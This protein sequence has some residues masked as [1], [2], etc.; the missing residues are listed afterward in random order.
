M[1]KI[2]IVLGSTR[3]DRAGEAI[4]QW[5]ADIAKDRGTN[6]DYE[7][8][9]LKS[10]NVPVLTS[11]VLPMMANKQYDDANVQ[12]WSNAIDACDA[13][14]FVTPEYNHS[15]PGPF[16][17]AFDSLGGEWQG[18]TIAFVGY[19]FSG[20]VR[21]VEAWRLA[22]ANFQ[23]NQL[24]S[25][26]EVSVITDFNEGAFAPADFKIGLVDNVLAE[27]EGTF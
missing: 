26:V 4:A 18:K 12:A 8:I 25:Q 21:A 15:V 5:V 3:D 16:K 9:D 13:F 20:G 1:A 27:I 7:L 23:M 17:N 19:G 22:V 6:F 10:F 24:R 2:G 11:S 14:V